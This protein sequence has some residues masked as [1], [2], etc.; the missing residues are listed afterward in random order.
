[1]D[2]EKVLLETYRKWNNETLIQTRARFTK[3][4]GIACRPFSQ[5]LRERGLDT[6]T[7]P[8]DASATEKPLDQ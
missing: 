4:G 5:V 7:C 8:P 2:V 6:G 1:M 3:P